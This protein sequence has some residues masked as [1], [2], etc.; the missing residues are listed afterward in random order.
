MRQI[1]PIEPVQDY[2]QALWESV[3]ERVS[4]FGGKRWKRYA[5]NIIMTE[6]AREKDL[7]IDAG[8]VATL[9]FAH[10]TR[11]A[12]IYLGEKPND[13][14]F[15]QLHDRLK[16]TLDGLDE[17]LSKFPISEEDGTFT[18]IELGMLMHGANYCK[19]KMREIAI[20][21]PDTT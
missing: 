3:C 16:V 7:V 5:W 4:F 20:H 1:K 11:L 14:G 2:I 12:L 13:D 17:T 15:Q 18:S 6:M 10:L 21:C 19:E 8:P 9:H